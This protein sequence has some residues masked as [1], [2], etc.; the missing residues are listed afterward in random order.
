MS[1][2]TLSDQE[3]LGDPAEKPGT[4]ALVGDIVRDFQKLIEQEWQMA[5]AEVRSEYRRA[6]AAAE[7]SFLGTGLG[8]VGVLLLGLALAQGFHAL[9]M[10]L[11]WAYALVGGLSLIAA[12]V[13]FLVARNEA[14]GANMLPDRSLK[15]LTEGESWNR[16]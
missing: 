14:K 6:K 4:G 2:T 11:G 16:N 1:T 7:L 15:A 8:L 13:L 10:S 12:V 5:K 9:G 3:R